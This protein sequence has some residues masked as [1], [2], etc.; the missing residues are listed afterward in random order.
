MIGSIFKTKKQET[1]ENKAQKIHETLIWGLDEMRK[2]GYQN[3]VLNV[4]ESET[5]DESETNNEAKR[6]GIFIDMNDKKLLHYDF[7]MLTDEEQKLIIDEKSYTLIDLSEPHIFVRTEKN[8]DYSERGLE[9]IER[10]RMYVLLPRLKPDSELYYMNK[11]SFFPE[12]NLK[13]FSKLAAEQG[14]TVEELKSDIEKGFNSY[15]KVTE[16]LYEEAGVYKS[17]EKLEK[18][19]NK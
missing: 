7:E 9:H 15:R 11:T 17:L 3:I 16:K 1:L 19:V 6:T 14:W 10:G 4:Y 2:K 18:K 13:E 8:K 12:K 5:H